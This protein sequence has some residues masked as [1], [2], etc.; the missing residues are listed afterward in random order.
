M[1]EFS[2]TGHE[3]EEKKPY[4]SPFL[5]PG[6]HEAVIR[7]VEFVTSKS[8]TGGIQFT[9]EGAPQPEGFVHPKGNQYKGKTANTTY[10]M[11]EKAWKYTK[12]N[13]VI[14]A[15]KLGARAALDAVKAPDPASYVAALAPIFVG[16]VARWKFA[17]EESL[18]KMKDDGTRY[19]NGWFAKLAG[20]GFVESKDTNPSTLTWDE[21][22]KFDMVKLPAADLEASSQDN[23]VDSTSSEEDP[24][25]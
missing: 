4:N 17:G 12:N 22:N 14:I 3:V 21:N 25:A 20:F 18:G 1:T 2:T 8:G 5:A 16:K 9:H 15:D 23:N 24:W 7:N 11:S 6:I 13:L 10:W 19:P